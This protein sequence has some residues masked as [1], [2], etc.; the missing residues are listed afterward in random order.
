[1]A[2]ARAVWFSFHLGCHRSAVSLSALNVSPLTQKIAPL[3]GSDICFSSPTSEGRSSPSNTPVFPPSSFIPLSF[4]WFCT[5]FL[6]LRSSCPLSAGV[7]HALLCLKVYSWCIS[8]ERCT[9]RPPTPPPSCSLYWKIF[10]HSLNF[11]ACDWCVYVFYF[12]L[13]QSWSVLSYKFVQFFQVVHFIGVYM[14]V[15]VSYDPL[16]FCDVSCNFSF[17]HFLFCF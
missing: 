8:G 2:V 1:M 17:F 6:L 15:V 9:Q 13:V 12:F 16:Y 5:S 11:I 14:L 10:D 7:Q 3:W 4:A